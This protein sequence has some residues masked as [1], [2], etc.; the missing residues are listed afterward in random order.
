MSFFMGV[1]G[2]LLIVRFTAMTN[3]WLIAR[4]N[5]DVFVQIANICKS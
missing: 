2:A 3:E 1:E 4:M 5:L